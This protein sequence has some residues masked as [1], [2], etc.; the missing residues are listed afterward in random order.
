[1]GMGHV[2]FCKSFFVIF[3]FG[4]LACS[5]SKNDNSI[6]QKVVC[7]DG[8]LH[9]VGVFGGKP[10]AEGERLSQ[11]TVFI[12]QH[13]G[14]RDADGNE[15]MEMCTGSLV[16]KN[17]ILTAAH[18]VPADQDAQ[19]VEIAF[20]VDPICQMHN[21]GQHNALRQAEQIIKHPEYEAKTDGFTKV[22]LAMIRFQGE[23]PA[24][25]KILKLLIKSV[26]LTATSRVV[27]AGYGQTTDY[28]SMDAEGT[29]LRTAQI[30]P[31]MDSD[32]PEKITYSNTLPILFFDQSH[33]SGAC[34]G[35]SGG[36]TL[37]QMPDSEY[38]VIG[39][40]SAVDS[41]T[42][43]GFG[44]QKDVTCMRGLRSASVYHQ[45]NWIHATHAVLRTGVSIG[46]SLR[47]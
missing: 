27:I 19:D 5:S 40:N 45:Q 3:S 12:L 22:D 38:V 18:C 4:V 14:I 35:D 31:V 23:A 42:K 17:I 41:T 28:N 15:M 37:L 21:E 11:G 26:N 6:S 36:P 39:V 47:K 16:D 46:L 34:A 13:V 1:M 2:G 25:E 7:H 24:G 30:T 32:A 43:A 20:S 44:D 10:V 29:I 8:V 9:T 33:G